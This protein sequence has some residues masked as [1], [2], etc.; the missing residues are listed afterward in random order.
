MSDRSLVLLRHEPLC[1]W[2]LGFISLGLIIQTGSVHTVHISLLL[3]ALMLVA[4][5]WFDHIKE[6]TLSLRLRLLTAYGLMFWIYTAVAYLIPL[7]ELSTYDHHLL[8][9]DRF[10]L[11]ETPAL[12]FTTR[13]WLTELMS[14]GYLSYQVYI[15]GSLLL[16]L[17][18][19]AYD[20]QQ[21]NIFLL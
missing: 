6:T 4:V 7:M 2:V 15:H 12:S 14:F 5:A 1:F 10:L 17:F 8:E 3:G 16:L 21:C 20:P 9:I 11:G 13:P 18:L 19:I